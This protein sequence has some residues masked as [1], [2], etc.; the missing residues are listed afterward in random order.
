MEKP[1]LLDGSWIICL[2]VFLYPWTTH[3]CNRSLGESQTSLT[4]MTLQLL[5]KES[6]MVPSQ[7]GVMVPS[8][9]SPSC[10]KVLSRRTSKGRGQSR[11]SPFVQVHLHQ[12]R[13]DRCPHYWGWGLDWSIH[14][15]CPVFTYVLYKTLQVSHKDM[16]FHHRSL[17]SLNIKWIKCSMDICQTKFCGRILTWWSVITDYIFNLKHWLIL[18]QV[19]RHGSVTSSFNCPCAVPGMLYSWSETRQVHKIR[20]VKVD[21][22]DP[23]RILDLIQELFSPCPQGPLLVSLLQQ[24]SCKYHVYCL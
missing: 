2:S 12:D 3:R 4:L 21:L 5:L 15:L 7:R 16:S 18:V 17:E 19:G 23:V 13:P 20:V 10:P 24:T 8:G 6:I 9:G 1:R 11:T 14:L 22:H